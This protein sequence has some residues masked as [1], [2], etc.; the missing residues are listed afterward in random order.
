MTVSYINLIKAQQ[1]PHAML[2]CS[3]RDFASADDIVAAGKAVRDRLM[4]NRVLPVLRVQR[5]PPKPLAV[6]PKPSIRVLGRAPLNMMA[7]CSAKFIIRMVSLRHGVTIKTIVGSSRVTKVVAARTEAM[8]LIYQ[9]TQMSTPAIGRFMNRDHTTVLH[10]LDKSGVLG[11]KVDPLAR[12]EVRRRP[13]PRDIIAI[14][15]SAPF[16]IE[17]GTDAREIMDAVCSKHGFTEIDLC[18][19]RRSDALVLARYEAIYR[20]SKETTMSSREIGRLLGG[21]DRALV[22]YAVKVYGARMG[23]AVNG[24]AQ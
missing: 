19:R 6:A 4:G 18:S 2:T 1:K 21:R 24:A 11:R 16:L 7:P 12:I 23:T 5:I 3:D 10:A 8:C 9:H 20:M 17:R 14:K 13:K 15:S 22:T